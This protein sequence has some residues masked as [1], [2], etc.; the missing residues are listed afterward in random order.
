MK[1]GSAN[2]T[3]TLSTAQMCK[4]LIPSFELFNFLTK[5]TFLTLKFKKSH[6]S[7]TNL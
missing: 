6:N 5:F 1:E 3:K 7:S 4:Y 2:L